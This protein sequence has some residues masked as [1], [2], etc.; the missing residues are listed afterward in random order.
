MAAALHSLHHS[1]RNDADKEKKHNRNVTKEHV[2]PDWSHSPLH[3]LADRGAYLVTA[4]TYQHQLHFCG[5]ERLGKLQEKLFHWA[6]QYQWQLQ[7]WAVLANHYHFVAVSDHPETL[8]IFVQQLHS[9]TGRWVNT[10]DNAPS[11]QVWYQYRETYLTNERSYLARLN[12][13]HH[14]PVHHQLVRDAREYPWCSARWFEQNV[15]PAFY[16]SVRSFKIEKLVIPE[17]ECKVFE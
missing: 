12:Y 11:R 13:V 16:K 17:A 5:R 14:N 2:M 8:E 9:E 6:S 1:I 3:R 7:A 4:A 10:K 15:S